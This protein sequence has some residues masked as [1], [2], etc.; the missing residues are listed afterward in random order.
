MANLLE[1]Y[2]LTMTQLPPSSTVK[3]LS[4]F[5]RY[6]AANVR[7]NSVL[8]TSI[9]SDSTSSITLSPCN[10]NDFQ[11]WILAPVL[12]GSNV[13]LFG[14]LQKVVTVSEQRFVSFTSVSNEFEFS[15]K[16]VND[17]DIMLWA[18]SITDRS[19]HT[20]QCVFPS[21]EREFLVT[22]N[23]TVKC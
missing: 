20:T 8:S 14:E 15:I 5:P 22:A 12:P 1:K 6:V 13:A 3:P 10:E 4:S 23:G 11:F 16:G 9:L 21:R 7:L 17:E 2:D 18:Y 19:I